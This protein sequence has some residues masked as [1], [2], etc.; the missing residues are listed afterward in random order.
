LLGFARPGLSPDYTIH[1][2]LAHNLR[3][4]GAKAPSNLRTLTPAR[5]CPH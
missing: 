2:E 3:N 5:P 1:A 4:L